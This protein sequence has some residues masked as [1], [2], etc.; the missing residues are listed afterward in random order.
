MT[1]PTPEQL[2][3]WQRLAGTE[4]WRAQRCDKA[5]SCDDT[6]TFAEVCHQDPVRTAVPALLDR[7]AELEAELERR[8]GCARCRVAELEENLDRAVNML[9]ALRPMVTSP[10]W[11][12]GPPPELRPGMLVGFMDDDGPWLHLLRFRGGVPLVC[13]L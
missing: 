9:D 13:L 12:D 2:A 3:E 4:W 8:D 5:P 10:R 11:H 1:R 6:C 7:V